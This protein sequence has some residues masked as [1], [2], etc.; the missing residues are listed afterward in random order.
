MARY[1][2]KS[3]DPRALKLTNL[4]F[5]TLET[6]LDKDTMIMDAQYGSRHSEILPFS[7]CAPA[8][9]AWTGGRSDLLPMLADQFNKGVKPFMLS[10]ANNNEGNPGTYRSYGFDLAALIEAAYLVDSS[11]K[12]Q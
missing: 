12:S 7:M 6:H 5:N 4:I 11:L 3:R 10:N 8:I 9:L 2:L 1:Y